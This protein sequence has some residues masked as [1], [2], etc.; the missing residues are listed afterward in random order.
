M[1]FLEKSLQDLA[2]ELFIDPET[3]KTP[4]E[5]ALPQG[6]PA[7]LARQQRLDM[8]MKQG[9]DINAL[10]SR[11]GPLSGVAYARQQ[12]NRLQELP[13]RARTGFGILA[14]RLRGE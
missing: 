1:A 5:A 14:D 12:L 9:V 2:P 13:T 10:R 6:S 3:L 8:L 7:A 11:T 4:Q